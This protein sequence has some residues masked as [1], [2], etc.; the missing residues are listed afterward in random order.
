MRGSNNEY[1]GR[2]GTFGQTYHT[3][4]QNLVCG[5]Y[6]FNQVRDFENNEMCIDQN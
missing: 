1:H 3:M 6:D 4:E 5:E 2:N